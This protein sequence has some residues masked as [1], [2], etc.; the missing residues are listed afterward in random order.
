[1]GSHTQDT[2]LKAH[3]TF[4][5][6]T[7]PAHPLRGRSFPV[8]RQQVKEANTL[9]IEIL[10]ADDDRR[11]VPA[12]WT[13]QQPPVVAVPHAR[14]VP[15]Q[16]IAL[17]HSLDALLQTAEKGDILAP[18]TNPPYGRRSDENPAS[19]DVGKTGRETTSPSSS[20]VGADAPTSVG[21][22]SER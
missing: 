7:H 8:V 5:Q 21:R 17:R 18:T 1:L 16:L 20:Y 11:W 3:S 2:P 4:V 15:M 6:I 9:F 13:N 22:A 19:V 10:V 14:F 12:D